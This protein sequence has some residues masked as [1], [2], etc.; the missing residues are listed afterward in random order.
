MY[1]GLTLGI[2]LV[3]SAPNTVAVGERY[4]RCSAV[5]VC[6]ANVLGLEALG[7]GPTALLCQVL[8]H[9]LTLRCLYQGCCL[10][11]CAPQPGVSPSPVVYAAVDAAFGFLKLD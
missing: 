3:S 5:G 1:T 10:S 11:K 7:G 6:E 4:Q 2:S 9:C 8:L